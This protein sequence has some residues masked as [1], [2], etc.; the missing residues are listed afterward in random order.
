MMICI[1]GIPIYLELLYYIGNLKVAISYFL[2]FN[3]ISIII[4]LM[5]FFCKNSEKIALFYR[6]FGKSENKITI[7]FVNKMDE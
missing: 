6:I 1:S 5:P 2:I 3:L 4:I 7:V